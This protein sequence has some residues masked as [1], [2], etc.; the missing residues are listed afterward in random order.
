[1]EVLESYLMQQIR[2]EL[3]FSALKVSVLSRWFYY[4]ILLLNYF[5]LF[6]FILSA[7]KKENVLEIVRWE[8]N[9]IQLNKRKEKEKEKEQV[10]S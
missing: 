7:I 9:L 6:Y 10:Q 3:A 1:M 5:I 2:L 4:S 8:A